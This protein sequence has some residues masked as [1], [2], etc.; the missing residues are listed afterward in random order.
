MID[1]GNISNKWVLAKVKCNSKTPPIRVD[2]DDIFILFLIYPN[3]QSWR[4]YLSNTWSVTRLCI[5]IYCIYKKKRFANYV[6][7][8]N[9][10]WVTASN[11]TTF[12]QIPM[13]SF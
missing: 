8:I 10:T 2:Y 4:K 7:W 12:L 9:Q 1:D 13:K 3:E 6:W 11:S 5:Y